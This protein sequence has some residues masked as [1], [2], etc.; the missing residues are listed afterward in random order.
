MNTVC[1]DK[2]VIQ[3][4]TDLMQQKNYLGNELQGESSS[5]CWLTKDKQLY[6][7]IHIN[8]ST[9]CFGPYG[10]CQVGYSIRGKKLHTIIWYSTNISV[11]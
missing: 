3:G 1:R 8:I 4:G 11:V 5:L 7:Q 2:T 9:T 6:C 10:H